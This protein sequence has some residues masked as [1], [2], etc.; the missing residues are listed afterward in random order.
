MR[1]MT[2]T[3]NGGFMS[4]ES[5]TL[6]QTVTMTGIE[7]AV[8]RAGGR[9]ALAEHLGVTPQVVANWVTQGYAPVKMAAAITTHTGV[10]SVH[11][12]DPK[13]VDLVQDGQ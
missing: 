13:I 12:L 4:N 6:E 7:A 2:R 9:R 11:L 10:P 5:N 8:N 1:P 3:I